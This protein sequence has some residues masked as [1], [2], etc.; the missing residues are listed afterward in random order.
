MFAGI[1]GLPSGGIAADQLPRSPIQPTLDDCQQMLAAYQRLNRQLEHATLDCYSGPS[2]IGAGKEVAWFPQCYTRPTIRAWP[3]CFPT[4]LAACETSK[5][6][7]EE[8]QLCLRRAQVDDAAQV[9]ALRLNKAYKDY[10]KL[11]LT[12]GVASGVITD[13]KKTIFDV[14]NKIGDKALAA[15]LFSDDGR[16]RD[17]HVADA[18]QI[19]ELVFNVVGTANNA[20]ASGVVRNVQAVAFNE[21]K[22]Y[23][24]H[25]MAELAGAVSDIETFKINS[26]AEGVIASRPILIP[27]ADK[28]Q[29]S[30]DQSTTGND[31]DILFQPEA[32]RELQGRN[33]EAW[34]ALV[35]K[36]SH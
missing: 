14:L 27:K 25:T 8:Y 22:H 17:E 35:G 16:L 31:C 13:P 4:E 3:Q 12:F 24:D 11:G 33:E 26:A 1:G 2:R 6:R 7:D 30:S 36:C 21:L 19:Y 23:F 10:K 20:V 15:T 28:Q 9:G 18:N 34:L 5:T 29:R 32:S